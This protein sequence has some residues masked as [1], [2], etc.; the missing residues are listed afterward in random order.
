MA[1]ASASPDPNNTE[2]DWRAKLG[3]LQKRYDALKSKSERPRDLDESDYDSEDD[4]RD[5]DMLWKLL[6]GGYTLVNKA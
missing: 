5:D 2:W 4:E 1:A 6:R 3:L